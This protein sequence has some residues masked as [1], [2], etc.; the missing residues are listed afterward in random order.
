LL[1]HIIV[2]LYCYF[3]VGTTIFKAFTKVKLFLLY[4]YISIILLYYNK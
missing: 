4:Y 1:L 2:Y 3:N